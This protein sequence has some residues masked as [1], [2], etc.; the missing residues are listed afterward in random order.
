MDD[1][2]NGK[3]LAGRYT[4]QSLIGRGGMAAVYQ[5]YDAN[6]GRT[7]AIKIIHPFYADNPD[8]TRRFADEAR[9]VAQFRQANIPVVYDFNQ[10]G[11]TCYMVMEYIAGETLEK[12][13]KTLSSSGQRL[14]VETAVQ[15]LL[16]LCDAAD[17]AHQR[18]VIH[19]DIKPANVILGPNDRV[20]LMD[21]GIAK[22]V[23]GPA[24]TLSGVTVGS[25]HY[26]APEQIQGLMLDARADIYA[27]GATFFEMLSGQP[28]FEADSAMTVMMMH[29]N[30]PLPDIRQLR[31]DAPPA[32]AAVLATA[33]A[34]GRDE[35]YRSTAEMAAALRQ[36]L[37][38]ASATPVSASP[39]GV[40][41]P[42]ATRI[43]TPV[44]GA[45]PLVPPS[46][47]YRSPQPVVTSSRDAAGATPPVSLAAAYTPPQAA[48]SPPRP[49]AVP[50]AAFPQTPGE[51]LYPVSAR[52]VKTWPLLLALL[53]I[54]ILAGAAY[55]FLL[56]KPGG[57]SPAE[58]PAAATPFAG[59]PAEALQPTSPGSPAASA[60]AAPTQ[61]PEPTATAP[62]APTDAPTV[63]PTAVPSEAPGNSG[64][65]NGCIDVATW[66]PYKLQ[67]ISQENGCWDL[68]HWGMTAV[69]D[70]LS[71]S[72]PQMISA[73]E[74]S[75]WRPLSTSAVI[76]V[77]VRIDELATGSP[78][79]DGL[80]FGIGKAETW[81]Q[82]GSYILFRLVSSGAPLQVYLTKGVKNQGVYVGDAAL[83]AEM[84]VE[85]HYADGE[86][87]FYLGGVA[88]QGAFAL[89]A[90]I[91][92]AP[93]FSLGYSLP[94]GGG[95]QAEVL[96]VSL[97]ER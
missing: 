20:Y 63:P 59:G 24:H 37:A 33:L 57:Q 91:V 60:V 72:M 54:G 32:V 51:S 84:D 39:P 52:R 74:R 29:L 83:G 64:F 18:G 49:A 2:F 31:P 95:I 5:A 67:G 45:A 11:E 30:D 61:L 1:G 77:K 71:I 90:A 97:E 28:P 70:R 73:S 88:L 9:L 35:R 93:V 56:A 38:G 34:K 14:P 53:V 27:L 68:S 42:G 41:P 89:P 55:Y 96:E 16:A 6:L 75:I 62:L 78:A 46:A 40:A 58:S 47:A 69:E 17:Y 3:T 48:A 82:A 10:E 92:Q 36:G 94:T 50:G 25:A 80:A 4:L 15:Y 65:I 13:L 8:F 23:G 81:Q 26:M 21:F 44:A 19:R 76:R 86:A 22:I 87:T 7:V 79:S 43:E 66:T 85:I 12:R